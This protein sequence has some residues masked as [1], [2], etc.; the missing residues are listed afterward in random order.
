MKRAQVPFRHGVGAKP[1][2]SLGPLRLSRSTSSI[3]ALRQHHYGMVPSFD[4]RQRDAQITMLVSPDHGDFD[5]LSL[6]NST[7]IE[8]CRCGG[9]IDVRDR[10]HSCKLCDR[11]TLPF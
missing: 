11:V 10:S 9:Q 3:D 1:G 8:T 4:R 6:S 7:T 5:A 2:S